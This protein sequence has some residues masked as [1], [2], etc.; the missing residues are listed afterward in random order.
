[1]IDRRWGIDWEGY[2]VVNVGG[3]VGDRMHSRGHAVKRAVGR[4]NRRRPRR[5]DDRDGSS[6]RPVAKKSRERVIASCCRSRRCC[7]AKVPGP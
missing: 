1:M 4:H 7:E 5:D 2:T 3:V 6:S